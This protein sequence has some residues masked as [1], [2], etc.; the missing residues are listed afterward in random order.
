MADDEHRAVVALQQL[1]EQLQRVNVQVVGGLVQH[2]HIG[3]TRKQTRQQQAVALAARQR[4]NRRRGARRRKQKI[5]QVAFDVF[6]L[7]AD[8]NPLAA[9]ADEVFQRR[10]HVQCI[11]Q[12]VKISHLQIRALPD[13]AAVAGQLAQNHFEQ[14]GFA[15]AVGANQANLVATQKRGRKI[16]SN[17]LVL[18]A[19]A[20]IGQ[21]GHQLARARA[22]VHIQLDL[23]HRIAPCLT[24]AA[25]SLQTRNAALAARAPRLHPFAHPHLFSRQQ[26][27]GLGIDHSFLRE[28]FFFLRLILRKIARIR[29]QTTSIQLHNARRNAIQK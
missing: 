27:V 4:T 12:L 10:V 28:L 23:P 9:R 14:G 24:L 13:L 15:H 26:L 21:F 2:Q 20:D 17:H 7:G 1:F 19:L 8:F 3:W 29:Q 6:A 25:Q 18:K 22:A 16:L 5:I 11:A